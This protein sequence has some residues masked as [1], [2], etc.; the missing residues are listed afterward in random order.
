[1]LDA[2]R[3]PAATTTARRARAALLRTLV[4]AIARRLSLRLPRH[5][6]VPPATA[7]G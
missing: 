2:Y 6:D 1:M 7:H 3:S 5:P 4:T